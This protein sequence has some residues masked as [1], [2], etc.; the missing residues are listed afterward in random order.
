MDTT[1]HKPYVKYEDGEIIPVFGFREKT[2]GTKPLVASNGSLVLAEN[3]KDEK[4]EIVTHQTVINYVN[5]EK[6]EEIFSK[7][8]LH[9]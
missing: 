3:Y 7:Q 2:T 8:I 9:G 1:G 6:N 4:Y 5:G